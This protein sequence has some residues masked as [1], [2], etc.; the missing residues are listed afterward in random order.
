MRIEQSGGGSGWD[1]TSHQRRRVLQRDNGGGEAS[2]SV[3]TITTADDAGRSDADL[4]DDQAQAKRELCRGR[5]RFT[6]LA[7]PIPV[8]AFGR[9]L[10]VRPGVQRRGDTWEAE[11]DFGGQAHMKR[12]SSQCAAA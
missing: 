5:L 6:A 12:V 11:R 3:L 4:G 2:A 10:G 8:R 9:I 1:R 7:G